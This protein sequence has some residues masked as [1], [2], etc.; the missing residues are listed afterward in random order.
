MCHN[1]DTDSV[2]RMASP[3][4]RSRQ[5][6]LVAGSTGDGGDLKTG[7][8]IYPALTRTTSFSLT[9]LGKQRSHLD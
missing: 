9:P 8:L 7:C 2:V 6:G 3:Q 1:Q 5:A 4:R